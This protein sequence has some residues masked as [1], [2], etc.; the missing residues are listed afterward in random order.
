QRVVHRSETVGKDDAPDPFINE[1]PAGRVDDQSSGDQVVALGVRPQV[2][3]GQSLAME[4]V[5][6]E[7]AHALERCAG[8]LRHR[9]SV[10]NTSAGAALAYQ[11]G[12][13]SDK[14]TEKVRVALI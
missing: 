11:F 14:A 10:T 12:S 7:P 2:R 4:H 8:R 1:T 6:I 13:G 3:I 9:N 5:A